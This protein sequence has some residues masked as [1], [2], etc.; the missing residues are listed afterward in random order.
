MVVLIDE[1]RLAGGRRSGTRSAGRQ[2]LEVIK[3]KYDINL[4]TVHS[5]QWLH[6]SGS[7]PDSVWDYLIR[8]HI[9]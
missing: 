3:W 6:M 4:A 9:C 7:L 5:L 8:G 2:M 1:C